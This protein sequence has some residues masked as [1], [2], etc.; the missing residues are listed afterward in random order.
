MRHLSWWWWCAA[1]CAALGDAPPPRYEVPK[2]AVA[3]ALLAGDG[4]GTLAEAC[5]PPS[6]LGVS[7]LARLYFNVL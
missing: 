5:G 1:A 3:E 4:N 6:R 2:V 7:L